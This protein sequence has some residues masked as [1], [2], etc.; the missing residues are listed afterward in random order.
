LLID[1]RLRAAELGQIAGG[2][3][4]ALQ[5]DQTKAAAK[6]GEDQDGS[7]RRALFPAEGERS[8]P[9]QVTWSPQV[10]G[11]R[12]S[13]AL[14]LLY[15]GNLWLVDSLSGEAWQITGDGLTKRLDWK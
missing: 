10:L 12:Q 4:R 1:H 5:P 2:L 8:D 9:Q 7:N 15:Q 14:A 3:F 13:H 11:G 6:L